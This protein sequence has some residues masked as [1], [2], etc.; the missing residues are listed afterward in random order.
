M[1][2]AMNMALK[3]SKAIEPILTLEE[4]GAEVARRQAKLGDTTLPRNTG[5]RRSA[6][7][8]ALLKAIEA[9]GGKW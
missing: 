2:Q 8:K 4:F 3:R 9:V 1:K 7:K 6:S 5:P